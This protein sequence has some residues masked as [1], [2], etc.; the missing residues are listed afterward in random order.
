MCHLLWKQLSY[1]AGEKFMTVYPQEVRPAL[2]SYGIARAPTP[3]GNRQLPIDITGRESE[4]H[5]K[6]LLESNHC[7]AVKRGRNARA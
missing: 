5:R 1:V 2:T 6:Q 4:L 3:L 7:N